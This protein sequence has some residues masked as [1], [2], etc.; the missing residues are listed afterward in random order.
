MPEPSFG[1]RYRSDGTVSFRVWS[2]LSHRVQLVLPGSSTLRDMVA[3]DDG[4]H[5][6]VEHVHP[7]ENYWYRLNGR[8]YPDPASSFQPEGVHGP[9]RVVNHGSHE[10]KNTDW[11]GD[12]MEDYVIY[13]LH[14]GTFSN[15]GTYGGV[16]DRIGHLKNLGINA[17]ELMPLAQFPGARNWGYDGVFPYS[18]QCT[19]G[20]VDELKHLVDE[21][22][23]NGINA[24]LDVVY[25][26]QGPEGNYIGNFAPYFTDRYSTPWGDAI[27]YDD[28]YS[29]MVRRFYVENALYWLEE[30]R[31]DAL[32]LDAVHGI[33][34]FSPKHILQEISE[35]AD[36]LAARTGRNLNII[37]ESDLNDPVLIR[38][39]ENCGYGLQGQWSDDFHHSL[40]SFITGE[41]NG[42]YSDFGSFQD[43]LK[44]V[45]DGFVY[46][47]VYSKYRNMTRG[48]PLGD[49]ARSRLVSYL[50]NHDQVG[51]RAASDRISTLVSTDKLR[52]AVALVILSPATP[53]IFMG[54]EYLEK[55]PFNYFI[56]TKDEKLAAAVKKGRSREFGSF[57]FQY[58]TDPNS[59]S[60]F[61][62]SKLD[63]NSLDTDEGRDFYN[64]L[65]NIIR[66][67]RRIGG[68]VGVFRV[69]A[70]CDGVI[71]IIYGKPRKF[72]VFISFSEKPC[73]HVS[74]PERELKRI[75]SSRRHQF[76]D[77]QDD[78]NDGEVLL[79][80]ETV[81]YSIEGE[82]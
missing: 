4:T 72:G 23:S 61:T 48:A 79:P 67:R 16:E 12:P 70:E 74:L 73:E 19:Y 78:M 47:G 62:S 49:I 22:H 11:K 32:R 42:Y 14:V 39:R 77:V 9:S 30:F 3:H 69:S 7:G 82:D 55:R 27:N 25:N 41:K 34:D 76:G 58:R 71:S 18:P 15:L 21:L 60:T 35:S 80:Y 54:E 5:E 36:D 52:A 45:A 64:Y 10:W 6:A 66:V 28:H 17:V 46:D 57:G 2:P 31:F 53:L 29:D 65:R 13:E 24:I 63:W 43:L 40:H 8:N 68:N 59:E 75:F 20:S 1:A 26:H 38:R 33:F 50:Q 56:D 81:V 44:A 37:A 51:N